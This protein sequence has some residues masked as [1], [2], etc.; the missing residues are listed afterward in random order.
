M[1]HVKLATN[2]QMGK[3]KRRQVK[4]RSNSVVSHLFSFP[5]SIA[6]LQHSLKQVIL[7]LNLISSGSTIEFQVLTDPISVVTPASSSENSCLCFLHTRFFSDQVRFLDLCFCRFFTSFIGGFCSKHRFWIL[8]VLKVK[9]F[10]LFSSSTVHVSWNLLQNHGRQIK[11]QQEQ[12]QQP[13]TSSA[14]PNR[15][16]FLI[17]C[18]SYRLQ[19]S[20]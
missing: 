5:Q 9:I 17:L 8:L 20:L 19:V 18:R 10:G 16:G 1:E 13:F 14:Y 11:F 15:H 4:D 3:S 7:E 6:L 2:N 12:N